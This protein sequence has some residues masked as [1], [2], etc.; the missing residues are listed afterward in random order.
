MEKENKKKSEM[1]MLR[2]SKEQRK[3]IN[4]VVAKSTY[5]NASEL[6][7][8]GIEKEINLQIYKDNLDV[9]V[10]ELSKLIDIKLDEF[11]KSQRKLI[12]K[13]VR[14]NA[15]N[16]YIMGEVMNRILGDE[17]YEEYKKIINKG[18]VKANYYVTRDT[19]DMSKEE[20]YEFY[21]IGDVYRNE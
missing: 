11:L 21:N 17:L 1:F 5:N 13:D 19:K 14:M 20:L 12:A 2:L 6:I 10:K 4:N 9:I 16:T 7:R 8:A 3:K 15:L 18:R